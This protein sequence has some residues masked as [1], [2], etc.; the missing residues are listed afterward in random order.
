MNYPSPD[1]QPVV[2]RLKAIAVLPDTGAN[3][4]RLQRA[5]CHLMLSPEMEPTFL[6]SKAD[7]IIECHETALRG[8][9]GEAPQTEVIRAFFTARERW[10]EAI[11]MTDSV[12]DVAYAIAYAWV[13]QGV[14]NAMRDGVT[15]ERLAQEVAKAVL[16][17]QGNACL[18]GPRGRRQSMVL[19]A[20]VVHLDRFLAA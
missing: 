13:T 1:H 4:K 9:N 12:P 2:T 5:I 18:S 14:M 10:E 17:W 6:D 15:V 11:Q 3:R 19:D 16:G 7:D 20:T 8:L